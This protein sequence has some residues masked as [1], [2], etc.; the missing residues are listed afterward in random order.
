MAEA[1]VGDTVRVSY[2]GRLDDGTV[3]DSSLEGDPLE[4]TLGT[5]EVIQGFEQAISGVE[6]GQSKTVTLDPDEA[7]GDRDEDLVF[8]VEREQLPEDLDPDVGDRLQ[9]RP[10][11][12][13]AFE[14]HVADVG[15]DRVVL[16][17]NH[18]L[19]G[20]ELTFEIELVEIV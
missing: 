10:Q 18:P 13:D 11:E 9:V 6:S 3:F 15:D 12:G 16:D 19:A 2:E 17:A 1:S 20:R 5:D 4:F 8:T 7:Y 14:V